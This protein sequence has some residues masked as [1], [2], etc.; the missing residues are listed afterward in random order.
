MNKRWKSAISLS[1]KGKPLER[2]IST[3]ITV[4]FVLMEKPQC[5]ITS[6]KNAAKFLRMSR[7]ALENAIAAIY[8]CTTRPQSQLKKSKK[9]SLE[10][11]QNIDIEVINEFADELQ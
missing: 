4:R 9:H 10:T 3:V 11:Q 5:T 2:K 8:I 1:Q 7:F 6:P